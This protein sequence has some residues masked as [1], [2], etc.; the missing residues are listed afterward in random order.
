MCM[1]VG[2]GV[3]TLTCPAVYNSALD[4]TSYL[5]RA[6][7]SS[8]SKRFEPFQVFL[9]MGAQLLPC[10]WISRWLGICWNFAKPPYCR[11]LVLLTFLLYFLCLFGVLWS[12]SSFFF[13]ANPVASGTCSVEQL[14]LICFNTQLGISR[15]PLNSSDSGQLGKSP[16]DGAFPGN[17]WTR[18]WQF[19]WDR[20]LS[21]S[22]PIQSFPR[23]C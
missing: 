22:K 9:Q 18:Q 3:Q 14:L 7:R 19:S 11:H 4:F 23:D 12:T 1:C 8:K 10:S 15:F 2:W 5:S 20:M 13:P 17:C 16:V 6:S 21:G